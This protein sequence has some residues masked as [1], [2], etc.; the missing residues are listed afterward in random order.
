M[1]WKINL[2][3]LVWKNGLRGR[4]SITTFMR[5]IGYFSVELFF[6]APNESVDGYNKGGRVFPLI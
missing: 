1:T 6:L 4:V 5:D 2:L 3:I